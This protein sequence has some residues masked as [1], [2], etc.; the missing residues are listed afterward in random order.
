[1]DL[2][3]KDRVAIVGGASKG[4]GRAC[5]QVLAAEGATVALCSR[6]Q[7]DLDKA[8]QEIRD[9]T[10]APTLAFAGDLDQ[11]DTIRA[12]IAATVERFRALVLNPQQ[13]GHRREGVRRHSVLLHEPAQ[14]CLL[15]HTIVA[16]MK[17][18][19]TDEVFDG[20]IERTRL[21]LLGTVRCDDVVIFGQ[22]IAEGAHESGLAD[23]GLALDHDDLAFGLGRLLPSLRQDA[24]L[25][26][27]T[28]QRCQRP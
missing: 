14:S 9:S 12:L 6:S 25:G 20:G 24:E 27:P 18:E 28:D 17:L 11:Y 23:A 7:A 15:L 2:E 21:V 16:G 10:G 1:M 3:L 4:L 19:R 22:A 26:L 5:A 8:A 13:G